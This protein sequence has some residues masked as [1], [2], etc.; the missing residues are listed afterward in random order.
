[1]DILLTQ[2]ALI[3]EIDH[4]CS[5]DI[6]VETNTAGFNI[7]T[8]KVNRETKADNYTYYGYR[9]ALR[10]DQSRKQSMNLETYKV[11]SRAV[12]LHGADHLDIGTYF[13]L[14]IRRQKS[15]VVI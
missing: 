6:V 10:F 12:Q 15:H 13:L 7:K 14:L 1:M 3:S 2:H 4:I 5:S 9:I 8:R 11:P